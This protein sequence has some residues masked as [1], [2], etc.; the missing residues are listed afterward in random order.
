MSMPSQLKLQSVQGSCYKGLHC[1]PTLSLTSSP[2][3][4]IITTCY[5][6]VAAQ[7][8]PHGT[9]LTLQESRRSASG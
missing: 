7:R 2:L 9:G 5:P 4:G 6:S 8:G 1:G 3:G